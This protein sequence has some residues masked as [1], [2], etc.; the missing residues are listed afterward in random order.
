MKTQMDKNYLDSVRF[1]V[2]SD[3]NKHFTGALNTYDSI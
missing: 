3:V 2:G 1:Q